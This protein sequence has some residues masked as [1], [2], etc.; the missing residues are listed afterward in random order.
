MWIV[1]FVVVAT[2]ILYAPLA[3]WRTPKNKKK[4][5]EM[6]TNSP[7]VVPVI[8]QHSILQINENPKET[9]LVEAITKVEALEIGNKKFCICVHFP[10]SEVL[11]NSGQ[12]KIK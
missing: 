11:K 5:K 8:H 4:K 7:F 1:L 2:S 10:K 9:I 3:F 12:F 6:L